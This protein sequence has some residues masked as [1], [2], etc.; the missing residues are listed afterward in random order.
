MPDDCFL[1]DHIANLENSPD[2]IFVTAVNYEERSLGISSKFDDSIKFK[3]IFV[4]IFNSEKNETQNNL[5][6][7]EN[8]LK[9]KSTNYKEIIASENKPM[10]SIIEFCSCLNKNPSN[11][12]VVLDI[13]TIP[14]KNLLILL[15]TFDDLGLWKNIRIYYTEPLNY[16]TDLY[17]PMS[18]GIGEIQALGE[19]IG[20]T[21]SSL[22]L[23]LLEFLGYDGDRARAVYNICEPDEA[24]LVIPKPA[25][26]PSWEGKTERMNN[27]L[28]KI[29]GKSNTV[30]ADPINVDDVI[31]TLENITKKYPLT[32]F[33]WTV[34]PMGTKPQALG[35]Y[36]FWKKHPNSFTI[37]H[38]DPLKNNPIFSSVGIGKTRLLLEEKSSLSNES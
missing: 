38:A 33:R 8:I 32:K 26:Y 15:K 30:F 31:A 29:V 35:L 5:K 34:V 9:E 6:K 14:I 4:F 25:F 20:N 19:F 23:L 18:I 2:D 1:I 37:L 21:S 7:L 3:N 36:L 17:L 11:P 28:L 24:T 10:G 22:Q 12:K 27:T 16:K 13:S